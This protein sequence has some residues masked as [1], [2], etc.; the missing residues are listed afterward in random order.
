MIQFEPAVTPR[1]P[2]PPAKVVDLEVVSIVDPGDNPSGAK[3]VPIKELVAWSP[4]KMA[5]AHRRELTNVRVGAAGS[6]LAG[7]ASL[8]VDLGCT[9]SA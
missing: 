4:K 8:K 5:R 9:S 2:T 3:D 7:Q 1:V 6:S